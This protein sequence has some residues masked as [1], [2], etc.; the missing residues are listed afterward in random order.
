MKFVRFSVP[1][2][3][4][5][6]AALHGQYESSGLTEFTQRSQANNDAF[7]AQQTAAVQQQQ[8]NDSLQNI[9]WQQQ[10]QAESLQQIQQQSL[11]RSGEGSYGD[12][13]AG[14]FALMH[15]ARENI[16]DQEAY[17]LAWAEENRRQRQDE[18]IGVSSSESQPSQY[19]TLSDADKADII[20]IKQLINHLKQ[21]QHVSLGLIYKKLSPIYDKVILSPSAITTALEND[22]DKVY[23]DMVS[24]SNQQNK[25][26]NLSDLEL[27]S[28][29]YVI[30][31]LAVS[32]RPEGYYSRMASEIVLKEIAEQKRQYDIQ[33]EQDTVRL[34][35]AGEELDACDSA[36]YQSLGI[37]TNNIQEKGKADAYFIAKLAPFFDGYK[38]SSCFPRLQKV[39]NDY[40]L[41]GFIRATGSSS[42]E[43]LQKYCADNNISIDDLNVFLDGE[44]INYS[45][46]KN[47]EDSGD[48]TRIQY[49]KLSKENLTNSSAVYFSTPY[50]NWE[51]FKSL[52]DRYDAFRKGQTAQ[53][54]ATQ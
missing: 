14:S 10:Q 22:K 45:A 42:Y 3:F 15:D 29:G 44:C 41:K 11:R 5:I 53:A 46:Y 17:N 43:E 40:F 51:T 4:A 12:A 34:K 9:Q 52:L 48:S 50:K 32:D 2:F 1:I 27:Q 30:L 19:S 23:K 13:L 28:K 47:P 54:A 16:R 18:A 38:T 7:R 33:Q 35:K 24:W 36:L 25:N 20:G 8:A 21:D 39:R 31:S 26:T 37:S 49:V 6:I